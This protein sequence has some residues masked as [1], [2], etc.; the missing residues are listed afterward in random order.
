MKNLQNEQDFIDAAFKAKVVKGEFLFIDK[1][2]DLMDR[3]FKGVKFENC[4]VQGGD[5]C[6]SDFFEC[7]FEN[8]QFKDTELPGVTFRNCIFE[9]CTFYN[10]NPSFS[11]IDCTVKRLSIAT[12]HEPSESTV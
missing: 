3:D 1:G 7:T 8:V 5:F 4:T 11:L 10:I 2:D 9:Q 6:S 12:M